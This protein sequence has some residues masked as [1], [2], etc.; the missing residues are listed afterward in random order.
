[1]PYNMTGK[2]KVPNIQP[3]ATVITILS[4][5]VVQKPLKCDLFLLT[6]VLVHLYLGSCKKTAVNKIH[7]K[8]GCSDVLCGWT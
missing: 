2:Q 7:V 1:M 4:G 6:I 3:V 5:R 8:G